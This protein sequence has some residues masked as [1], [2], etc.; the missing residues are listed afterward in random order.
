MTA[1]VGV[2]A[3]QLEE[4]SSATH[5][6]LGDSISVKLTCAESGDIVRDRSHQVSR[7]SLVRTVPD[8]EAEVGLGA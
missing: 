4:E 1:Q 2:E 7:A 3:W 6:D 5:E 8:G